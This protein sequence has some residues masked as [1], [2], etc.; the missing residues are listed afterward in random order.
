MLRMKQRLP[1][2]LVL[3]AVCQIVALLVLPLT[4]LTAISPAIWIALVILFGLLG[5]SLLRRQAW[6]RTATIFVQGFNIIVRLLYLVGHAVQG[7]QVGSPLD[8]AVV[9]TFLLSMI[10]SGVVLYYVDLPDVQVALQ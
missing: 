2:G 1:I 8:T 10:L 5:F 7:G 9:G 3:V 6:S 4:A